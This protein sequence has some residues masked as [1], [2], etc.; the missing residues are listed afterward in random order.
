M[1][2]RLS[3]DCIFME[4]RGLFQAIKAPYRYIGVGKPRT[5]IFVYDQVR[6]ATHMTQALY[7]ALFIIDKKVADLMM[8]RSAPVILWIR[9]YQLLAKGFR[10]SETFLWITYSL[11]F[12]WAL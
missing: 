4:L 12:P 3:I 10:I 1:P 2:G 6:C 8:L 7:I 5:T 11:S 9:S